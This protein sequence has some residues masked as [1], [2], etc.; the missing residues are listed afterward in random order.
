MII[1]SVLE[2]VAGTYNNA[3]EVQMREMAFQSQIA[4][5]SD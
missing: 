3:E 4:T 5:L 2:S 1:F